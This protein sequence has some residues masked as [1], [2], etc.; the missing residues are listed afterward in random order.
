MDKAIE[1]AL[2]TW[3]PKDHPLHLDPLHPAIGLAGECGELLDLYKKERFKTGYSWWDCVHCSQPE[4]EHSKN[5][6]YCGSWWRKN[7]N[8]TI[9]TPK[10]LDELGDAWYYLRILAYQQ[11]YT[12][13]TYSDERGVLPDRFMMLANLNYRCAR[14]LTIY[15]DSE[16]I[17]TQV[18]QIVF[19][20]YQDILFLL[21]FTLD[22][23]TESN[24]AKLQ[25][26]DNHGWKEAR[27]SE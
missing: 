9:Y 7:D 26:N 2:V 24:Y 8:Q 23:V 19:D 27:E 22:Q 12:F 16:T 4:M 11:D 18:L 20:W 5:N 14:L 21:G 17:N 25:R 6:S 13:K 1:Y 3:Y 10:I 15:E